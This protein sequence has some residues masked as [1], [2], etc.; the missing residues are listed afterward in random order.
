MCTINHQI[1]GAARCGTARWS[2]QCSTYMHATMNDDDDE[3]EEPLERN[4]RLAKLRKRR[5]V[6]AREYVPEK[7]GFKRTGQDY[8]DSQAARALLAAKRNGNVTSTGVVIRRG[9]SKLH[10]HARGITLRMRI[11]STVTSRLSAHGRLKFTGQKTGVGVYMEK[12]FVRITHIH[13]DHRII[14]KRD[15]RLLGRIRYLSSYMPISCEWQGSETLASDDTAVGQ[16]CSVPE[17]PATG[18]GELAH[19]EYLSAAHTLHHHPHLMGHVEQVVQL[20]D[21]R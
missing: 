20:Y 8:I 4:H 16:W 1:C 7:W 14:K 6:K 17:R 13:T 18:R 3:P 2:M 21:Q 11:P 15:G 5:Y 9:Q 10:S 12:P 19:L